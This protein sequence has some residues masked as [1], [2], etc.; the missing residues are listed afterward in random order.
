MK[1]CNGPCNQEKEDSEFYIKRYKNGVI[2]LRALCK[3][4]STLERDIWRKSSTK[5]N[6]RNKEY[7]KRNAVRIRGNKLRKYW[8]GSTCE[9]ALANFEVLFKAQDGKCAICDKVK[10]L[11]VDHNHITGEV[12]G[13]L[14]NKC[15]RGLGLFDESPQCFKR[16][17]V[18]L[19]AA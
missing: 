10:R 17:L 11:A 14:C 7:N 1:K 15:N 13:L 18:Y 5:D 4:C 9:Q 16:S 3:H 8:P 2:G 12:R 6:D 19:K